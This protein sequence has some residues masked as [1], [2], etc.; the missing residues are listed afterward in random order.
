MTSVVNRGNDHIEKLLKIFKKQVEKSGLFADLRK[1]EFYE[2][3]SVR[4]KRKTAAARK[5]EAKQ[6]RK[7]EQGV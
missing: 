2:K 7:D 4:K 1:H 3:P 5:R 6:K